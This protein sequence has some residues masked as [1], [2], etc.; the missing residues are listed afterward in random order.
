M[1]TRVSGASGS[2]ITSVKFLPS[3]QAFSV[4]LHS[5]TRSARGTSLTLFAADVTI[6]VFLMAGVPGT[7]SASSKHV[8]TAT[9][10]RKFQIAGCF[11]PTLTFR[12]AS[13]KYC[14]AARTRQAE[15]SRHV[16]NGYAVWP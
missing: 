14:H 7:A 5:F 10:R 3:G 16:L 11:I 13:S 12:Q 8:A 1:A 15:V 6:A 9:R 2:L 4:P